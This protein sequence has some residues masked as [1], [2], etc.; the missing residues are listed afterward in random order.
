MLNKTAVWGLRGI[1]LAMLVAASTAGVY[2]GEKDALSPSVSL[3]QLKLDA[4]RLEKSGDK[5]K[6]AQAYEQIIEADP[7]KSRLL[8]NRLALLYADLGEM[9]KSLKYAA[10]VMRH[11]PDPKA[12]LAGIYQRAGNHK[13]AQ[14]ILKDEISKADNPQKKMILRWQLADSYEKTGDS[15]KAEKVLLN[16]A[17]DA[18]KG[19]GKKAAENRLKKF[20]AKSEK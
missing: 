18:P 8:A 17:A 12:Y 19:A 9:D 11:H 3:Q 15:V 7:S 10:V 5:V 14:K 6:A 13:E 2:A 16:A 20:K 4:V 1:I